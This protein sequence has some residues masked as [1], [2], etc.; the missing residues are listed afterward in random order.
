MHGETEHSQYS[1]F[2]SI[3]TIVSVLRFGFCVCVQFMLIVWELSQGWAH[4]NFGIC[5]HCCIS[6]SFA[7]QRLAA[8][9]SQKKLKEKKNFLFFFS[10]CYCWMHS[11]TLRLC[12]QWL[13][14]T[15]YLPRVCAYGARAHDLGNR[16]VFLSLPL[17]INIIIIYSCA[18]SKWKLLWENVVRLRSQCELHCSSAAQCKGLW[19]VGKLNGRERGE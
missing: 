2:E 7:K 4:R 8:H 18:S 14:L 12:K 6:D 13:H 9:R 5:F 1:I 10:Q 15:V 16:G 3:W 11:A 17:R 19:I